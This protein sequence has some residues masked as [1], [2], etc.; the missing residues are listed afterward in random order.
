MCFANFSS[1]FAKIKIILSK[2]CVLWNLDK[3]IFNFAKLEENFTKIS[4]NYK[5][6]NFAATQLLHNLPYA[7]H[8]PL[9]SAKR[10]FNAAR[11]CYFDMKTIKEPC[12]SI[13]SI[14]ILCSKHKT[15][16]SCEGQVLQPPT[17]P[18]HG[19][20]SEDSSRQQRKSWRE[21]WFMSFYSL[22]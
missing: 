10:F 11:Q 2:F 9:L 4:R 3:L 17:S 18:A 20:A 6:E 13:L 5:N 8:P 21:R 12:F 16:C 7:T 15:S 19:G 22:G 1:N 14:I